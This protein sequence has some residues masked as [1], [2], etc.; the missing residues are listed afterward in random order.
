MGVAVKPQSMLHKAL[1]FRSRAASDDE[2]TI[3]TE[4]EAGGCR[5]TEMFKLEDE[6]LKK[7]RN[8][9]DGSEGIDHKDDSNTA[10]TS[11]LSEKSQL[12]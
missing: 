9:S 2:I 11:L 10:K 3:I 1:S 12:S 6:C 5:A 8:M 4:E 7:E